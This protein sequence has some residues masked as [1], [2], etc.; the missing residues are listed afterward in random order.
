MSASWDTARASEL[1]RRAY[2]YVAWTYPPHANLKPLDAPQD[3]ILEAQAA[4]DF[5][6][7]QQ[8]LREMCRVAKRE[9]LRRRAA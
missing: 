8:A 3:A 7:Y 4:G 2:E 9:A 1:A 5:E 6:G